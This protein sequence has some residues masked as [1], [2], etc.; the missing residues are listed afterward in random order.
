MVKAQTLGPFWA[1]SLI[2]RVMAE[3]CCFLEILFEIQGSTDEN[4]G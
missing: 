4:Q 1:Y 2:F 3:D